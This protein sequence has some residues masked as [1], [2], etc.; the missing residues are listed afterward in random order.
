MFSNALGTGFGIKYWLCQQA[1]AAYFGDARDVPQL[2]GAVYG[3]FKWI[4]SIDR[5]LVADIHNEG[6]EWVALHSAE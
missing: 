6:R 4:P 3:P 2:Y 5:Q 1:S